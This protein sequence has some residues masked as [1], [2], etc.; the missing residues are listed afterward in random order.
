MSF[1]NF[2]RKAQR[3]EEKRSTSLRGAKR[4]FVIMRDV[5]IRFIDK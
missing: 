2:S 3:R 4:W 5:A 1:T